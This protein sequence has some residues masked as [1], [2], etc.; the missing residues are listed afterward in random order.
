MS[1][2]DHF[3]N[4]EEQYWDSD[5][6][7]SR[8]QRKTAEKKDRSKF[9]KSNQDQLLKKSKKPVNATDI[10]GRVLTIAA[11]RITVFTD[12]HSYL[13]SLKG[14]LKQEHALM[15][16]LI[17]V[18]DLV[19]IQI[20]NETHAVITQVLPRR[21]ILS[22]ADN[23]SRNKQQ[24]IATNVDQVFIT[25]SVCS[26]K[27][28]PLLIDRYIIAAQKG[29]IC[30]IILI[31]KVDLL[32]TPLNRLSLEAVEE[33]KRLYEEFI[34]TYKSLNFIVI[35]LS[36]IT[37]EGIDMLKTQMQNKTSVFSGQS[38]VGKS[39]LINLVT[40]LCFATRKV[41]KRTGK[42]S[43]TTTQARMIPLEGRSYC[44]DTP[45][46]QSF[47]IWD[48]DKK[49][50]SSYFSE[51]FTASEGCQFPNCTHRREPNCAVKKA[52]EIGKISTLRFDSYCA[53]MSS[54]SKKHQKR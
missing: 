42:G 9:K 12:E 48:I 24:L 40:G 28:K 31:N 41:V 23:L 16:N 53:L 2:Q 8:K 1:K 37:Q 54:L 46:I 50:L 47:G 18:G 4:W 52:V 49:T 25:A 21:S 15:K 38:G 6:K 36:V 3:L 43:H 5:R 30:P 22:R 35:P 26:P 32:D 44:I 19:L 7:A 51:I 33:E 45:G 34:H 10:Q 14:S 13:C 17:A 27:L 20:I 11:D 39:S 29:N